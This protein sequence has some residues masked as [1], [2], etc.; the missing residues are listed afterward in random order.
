MKYCSILIKMAIIEK[1]KI[2]VGKEEEK[3]EP[4]TLLVKI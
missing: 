2:S 4:S 1:K 3:L